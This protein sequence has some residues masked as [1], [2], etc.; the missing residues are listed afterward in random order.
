MFLINERLSSMEEE[1]ELQKLQ[2]ELEETKSRL[3]AVTSERDALQRELQIWGVYQRA[4]L[5]FAEGKY[6][7]V[8]LSCD[9]IL[10]AKPKFLEAHILKA[11]AYLK[12]GM[13]HE[14]LMAAEA[15]LVACGPQAGAYAIKAASLRFLN[16]L[17]EAEIALQSAI[18]LNSAFPGLANIR[19]A[20]RRARKQPPSDDEEGGSPV[21]T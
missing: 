21:N 1:T 2:R 13:H 15:A 17:E 16:K 7:L 18:E 14:A 20:I 12:L 5:Q 11:N 19:A 10:V 8:L 3:E 4:A 6:D 9:R